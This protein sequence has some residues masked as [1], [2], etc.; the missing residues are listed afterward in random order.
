[1]VFSIATKIVLL[2]GGGGVGGRYQCYKAGNHKTVSKE[3]LSYSN[4]F[5]QGLRAFVK[6]SKNFFALQ[7][8]PS[9]LSSLTVPLCVLK[10]N[11]VYCPTLFDINPFQVDV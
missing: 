3:F 7:N 4:N 10:I 9:F 1:M 5:L 8:L 2:G 6:N 11:S